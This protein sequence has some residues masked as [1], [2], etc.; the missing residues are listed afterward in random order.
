MSKKYS[1]YFLIFNEEDKGFEVSSDKQPTGYTKIETKNGKCKITVY[2]QNLKPDRGPYVCYLIDSSKKTATV[3]KLGEISV[4]DSGKGEITWQ[5]DAKNILGTGLAFDKFNVAAV[6]KEGNRLQVPLAGY[7]EKEKV[8]WRDKISAR[9]FVVQ[10]ESKTEEAVLK[11]EDKR[12]N[13]KDSKKQSKKE[14]RKSEKIQ[15]IDDIVDKIEEEKALEK[16]LETTGILE[17]AEK[18]EDSTLRQDAEAG[19]LSENIEDAIGDV[20]DISDTE[21]REFDNIRG[22]EEDIEKAE[23][24]RTQLE[25]N[26]NDYIERYSE[27]GLV[28]EHYERDI[29]LQSAD[30]SYAENMT[31][32]LSKESSF[33]DSIEVPSVN[34]MERYDSN[35]LDSEDSREDEEYLC[36]AKD[37]KEKLDETK[38]DEKGILSTAMKNAN[39]NRNKLCK[40]IEQ[41][42]EKLEKEIYKEIKK[43]IQGELGKYKDSILKAVCKDHDSCKDHDHKDHSHHHHHG[44]HEHHGQE[45]GCSSCG[46]EHNEHH[47]HHHS[48]HEHHHDEH[49]KK[50]Y[51][52][53]LHKILKDF[54]EENIGIK[55]CKFWK[56]HTESKIPKKDNSLYPYYSA[57]HHLKMTYPYINYVKY[58]KEK[59]HYYF[60]IQYDK[61]GE[62]KYLIYA[63]EGDKVEKDQPYKGMTGFVS[64]AP[65]KQKGIWVMYYNPYTGCVMLPKSKDKKKS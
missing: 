15:S 21:T 41:D 12:E 16:E 40:E 58:F 23:D 34:R 33:N 55:G 61:Q 54:K 14:D 50:G 64:W 35:R 60:G 31:D 42:L 56:V 38:V 5:E 49:K 32:A 59:G 62:V 39:I 47:S 11:E 1:R 46:E 57:V 25:R 22:E 17:S 6:V 2:A 4:D 43:F 10:E 13:K 53:A 48:H 20:E 27:E 3:A 30:A 7:L 18:V 29:N 63:I 51:A 28:F 44:H 37:L 26:D 65:Y 9:S 19:N 45:G 36:D 24:Y 8:Q 52:K